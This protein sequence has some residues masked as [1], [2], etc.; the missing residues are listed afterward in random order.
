[1]DEA[2]VVLNLSCSQVNVH[3]SYLWDFYSHG[4]RK[5]LA[6]T[7]DEASQVHPV[8]VWVVEAA[9]LRTLWPM[10]RRSAVCM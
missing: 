2:Q 10:R 5:Q 3:L 4:V 1:M 7:V 6:Q 9:Q 8:F